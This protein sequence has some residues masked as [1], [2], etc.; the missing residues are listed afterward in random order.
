MSGLEP[1][2][3]TYKTLSSLYEAHCRMQS[4]QPDASVVRLFEAHPLE[5]LDLSRLILNPVDFQAV[6]ECC[7]VMPSLTSLNLE[8]TNPKPEHI[9]CLVDMATQSSTLERISLANNPS[10]G[11][12][13]ARM[14]LPMIKENKYIVELNVEGT[15]MAAPTKELIETVL[16]TNQR[17]AEENPRA[18]C[19]PPF[20][21]CFLDRR[22]VVC[23]G[24]HPW[25]VCIFG[26]CRDVLVLRLFCR[27]N[28][29]MK[30]EAYTQAQ[31]SDLVPASQ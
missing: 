7:L 26:R 12:S 10:L 1:L 18:V 31:A 13:A 19:Y 27:R 20:T 11:F 2:L 28:K 24:K 29:L 30:P 3:Q 21:F 22:V 9:Q 15:S 23:L 25:F 8:K 4:L 16:T 17:F 5:E 14:L 6:M